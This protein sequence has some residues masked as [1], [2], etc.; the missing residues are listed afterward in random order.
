MYEPASS[1]ASQ[2]TALATSA[3]VPRRAHGVRA[4]E[5]GATGRVGSLTI[6]PG[7]TAL[8]VMRSSAKSTCVTHVLRTHRSHPPALA[9]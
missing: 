7:A 9:P 3:G 8:H 5:Y 2:Q 4:T 1:L 6:L